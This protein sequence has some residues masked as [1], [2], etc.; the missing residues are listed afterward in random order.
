MRT[1]IIL[2]FLAVACGPQMVIEKR[3]VEPK[4]PATPKA[5]PRVDLSNI[6]I[7]VDINIELEIKGVNPRWVR[8][9]RLLFEVTETKW[10][11]INGEQEG[12][13]MIRIRQDDRERNVVIEED[14]SKVVYGYRFS[15]S[16]A[17]DYFDPDGRMAPHVKLTISK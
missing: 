13:A 9:T 4:T 10:N 2:T 1:L 3:P 12:R 6:A 17:R 5:P 15:V 11:E 14:D 8:G 7:P 16:Y